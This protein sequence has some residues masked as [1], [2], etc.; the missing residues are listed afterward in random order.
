[1]SVSR[2]VSL[3]LRSWATS[4]SSPL[5]GALSCL[6]VHPIGHLGPGRGWSIGAL[7][8][9]QFQSLLVPS[10]LPSIHSRA[11]EKEPLLCAMGLACS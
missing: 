1:M 4:D 10:S 7:Q 6:G 5:A 11:V 2:A 3:H 8:E 9:R